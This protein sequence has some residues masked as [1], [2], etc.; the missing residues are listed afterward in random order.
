[1][2]VRS[3]PG[4]RT[5]I[6][7]QK[8][9]CSYVGGTFDGLAKIRSA[10]R[11]E[12]SLVPHPRTNI[13][14]TRAN[15]RTGS[16]MI[17]PSSPEKC[18]YGVAPKDRMSALDRE[19]SYGVYAMQDVHPAPVRTFHFRDGHTT[20]FDGLAKTRSAPRSEFSLV[21]RPRTNISNT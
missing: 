2:F 6:S 1:M 8:W 4:S 17:I 20:A 21:P 7:R 15:V 9:E 10:P 13:P 3:P 16:R 18:S 12:F 19:C 5:N 11:S 14:N